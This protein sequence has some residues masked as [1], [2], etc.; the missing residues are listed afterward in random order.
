MGYMVVGLSS[1]FEKGL[2]ERGVSEKDL[3]CHDYPSK[4]LILNHIT[5]IAAYISDFVVFI[6]I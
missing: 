2:S 4:G 5:V 3:C 1:C 6:Y